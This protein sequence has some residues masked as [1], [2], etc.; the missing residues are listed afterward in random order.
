MNKYFGTTEVVA[1]SSYVETYFGQ[2]KLQITE[3]G[4]PVRADATFVRHCKLI[5]Y[6]MKEAGAKLIN[7]TLTQNITKEAFKVDEAAHLRHKENWKNK[8]K[9][10]DVED[11]LITDS[12]ENSIIP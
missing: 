11:P 3:N 9:H 12:D 5:N 6:D 7:F 4:H 10:S 1:T 2:R 8:N